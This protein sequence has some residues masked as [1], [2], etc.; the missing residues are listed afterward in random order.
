MYDTESIALIQN[1]PKLKDLDLKRLPE[2][3]AT[4]FTE[5]VAFRSRIREAA[6]KE[7]PPKI[8]LDR[9]LRLATTYESY[10]SVL[11][12]REDR[13]SAAFVSGTAYQLL[14]LASRLSGAET[15]STYLRHDSISTDVSAL[16]LFLIAGYTG[17][18]T[19]VSKRMSIQADEPVCAYLLNSLIFL[20]KGEL[21][22]I[23]DIDIP[24]VTAD[25]DEPFGLDRAAALE[26]YREAFLGIRSLAQ[27]LLSSEVEQL[28]STETFL[29]VMQLAVH[30]IELFG[31]PDGN[32]EII[33]TFSGPHHLASLLVQA[34]DTL[35]R[36]AIVRVDAPPNTDSAQWNAFVRRVAVRRPYL[37]KNHQTAIESGYLNKGVSSAI[38]FPTGA[39]KSTV[40]E[41][42]IAATLLGGGRVLFLVPT[43]ALLSQVVRDLKK[44][45]HDY[46]VRGTLL[47][48]G[49]YS[50][51]EETDL[52]HIS[53]MTP[54]R[55][56][57]QLG[58][59]PELFCNLGLIVFDECH[60]LHPKSGIKDQRSLDSMLCVLSL[61]ENASNAD[62]TLLS[63]MMKNTEEI[64]GWIGSITGRTCL[65]LDLDW[66]PTRQARG[67]LIYDEEQLTK[68]Q[69]TIETRERES[70]AL[71]KKKRREWEKS[72]KSKRKPKYP[73][74]PKVADQKDLS[75]DPKVL[76][77]LKQMWAG[78]NF[79][80][81]LVVPILG[82]SIDLTA[83]KSWR[84]T[85]NR[86]VVAA[87]IA[88]SFVKSNMKTLVFAQN[89]TWAKKICKDISK[90]FKANEPL[91]LTSD[92]TRWLE[93]STLEAGGAQHV[94]GPESVVA[95]H[96]GLLLPPERQLN[97]LAFARTDGLQVLAATPTLAQGINLPAEVVIMA[98]DDRF[99]SETG[100]NSQ[101]E[102]HELLNAAGRAGRAGFVS[103]GVVLVIPGVN[104]G[105]NLDE[106]RLSSRWFQLK[107]IFANPDKCLEIEDP[108]DVFLDLL[109][110]EI[111]E[112]DQAAV[113]YFLTRLPVGD[114]QLA[115][116]LLSKSLAGYKAQ[117]Q[118]ELPGFHGKIINA[119]SKR[120]DAVSKKEAPET[121]ESEVSA[122]TGFDTTFVSDLG[123]AFAEIEDRNKTVADW[124]SWYFSWL[125]EDNGRP[126]IGIKR[127]T[128]EDGSKVGKRGATK[129]ELSE[130]LDLIE[131]LT[132]KW[133]DGA[134]LVELEITMGIREEKVGNCDNARKFVT[135]WIRD[136]SYGVGVV[137]LIFRKNDKTKAEKIPAE[138]AVAAS[139]LKDGLGS[140]ELLALSHVLQEPHARCEI[141]QLLDQLGRFLSPRSPFESFAVTKHRTKSAYD[142]FVL[143]QEFDTI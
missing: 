122:S 124:T 13:D 24:Q 12:R 107:E 36:S 32:G 102:A 103:Q 61:L 120:N 11:R 35:G 129:R 131:N 75:A 29:N 15:E 84:L 16:L 126:S 77:C 39:G 26:L 28:S 31:N 17:D 106:T 117:E 93:I 9:L 44:T 18:A 67:C 45:F 66:K 125:K 57:A 37:W 86:N 133:L 38:S 60:L 20:A 91:R 92:E 48:D 63:A 14:S 94:Y 68:L 89:I 114:D 56:L 19:E 82:G 112:E 70:T 33:N 27:E 72:D 96:H 95:C 87:Q 49:E 22:S 116:Q 64:S 25:F 46:D 78:N 41:L 109:Q 128:L 81:Y 79:E 7:V 99:D 118:S 34:A 80:D 105:L 121:W 136:I 141:R 3:L 137:A 10:V 139:C 101:L 62:F 104:V 97:E 50:E 85:A 1:A 73:P 142:R 4:A 108:I 5:I 111:E 90:H 58:I 23:V 43:H 53:V 21:N 83:N 74:I 132:L 140:V 110:N 65:A 51:I 54:E 30:E 88:A 100:F 119:I 69:A 55:C 40:S 123:S 130:T 42:K 6:D 143:E 98:G 134:T 135:R 113:D 2:E 52:P 47:V 59:S 115:R 127:Q 8:D 71:A 76:F 138:L